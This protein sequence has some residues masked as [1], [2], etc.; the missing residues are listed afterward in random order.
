VGS[1]GGVIRRVEGAHVAGVTTLVKDI[2][3]SMH[4][5]KLPTQDLDIR[6]I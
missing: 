2:V 6:R 3:V 5:V 1:N 4:N